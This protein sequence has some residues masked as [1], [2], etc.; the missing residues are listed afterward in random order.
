YV[1]R[2]I[3]D[4]LA[5]TNLSPYPAHATGES[6]KK[7]PSGR[8]RRNRELLAHI[9]EWPLRIR[10]EVPAVAQ[11]LVARRAARQRDHDLVDVEVSDLGVR[12]GR[13]LEAEVKLG[14]REEEEHETVVPDISRL[15]RGLLQLA[16][17]IRVVAG[18]DMAQ[19]VE[20]AELR[21]AV[22]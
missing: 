11:I 19:I 20:E 21:D 10:P 5:R 14:D 8:E 4:L 6:L 13:D 17:G 9:L 2:C 16:L 12:D 1:I 18:E 3:A 15:E 22:L 7:T